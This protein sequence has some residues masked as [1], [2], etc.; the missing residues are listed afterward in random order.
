MEVSITKKNN[1][2]VTEALLRRIFPRVPMDA[3]NIVVN[4]MTEEYKNAIPTSMYDD[5]IGTVLKFLN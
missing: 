5:K 2:K 3:L 4:N 1:P